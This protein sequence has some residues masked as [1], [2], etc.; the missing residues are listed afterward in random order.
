MKLTNEKVAAMCRDLENGVLDN[1]G[2]VGY[3]AARN[4]RALHDVAEPFF[5]QRNKLIME[6]GD[7]QY[8]GDGNIDDYVVDPKSEKFAAFAAKYQELADIECEVEILTLPEEKA[9][10]AISGAQLLQL[11]W[12]FE[13]G[14]E[15]TE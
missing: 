3:T 6:Y 4:Y 5:I 1:V 11:S 8:D 9:I 12:M 2:I 13:R 15:A 14:L 10:D 7:A